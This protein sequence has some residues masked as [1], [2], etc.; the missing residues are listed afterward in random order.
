MS[1]PP[2]VD[3]NMLMSRL[4][5]VCLR[6]VVIVVVVVIVFFFSQAIYNKLFILHYYEYLAL[7][8]RKI[9]KNLKPK[10]RQN[11]ERKIQFY[12]KQTLND[13]VIIISEISKE[14]YSMQSQ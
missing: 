4:F 14:I 8:N 10:Q 11:K 6:C 7:N 13:T 5:Y 12:F 1:K 3:F 9:K 2:K